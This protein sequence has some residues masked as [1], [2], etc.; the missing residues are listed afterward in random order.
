[1]SWNTHSSNTWCASTSTATWNN[2]SQTY[3]Y[4]H[5]DLDID[6][7]QFIF[8]LVVDAGGRVRRSGW[9]GILF[10][11]E[12][13]FLVLDKGTTMSRY[14]V[15]EELQ[16]IRDHRRCYTYRP[17]IEDKKHYDALML[18]RNYRKKMNKLI[19]WMQENPNANPDDD[20]K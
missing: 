1:M 7:L 3:Y 18:F 8:N 19:D 14:E 12:D 13:E 9:L 17:H 10:Q 16:R 15:M 20:D 4:K 2:H 11:I 5:I 6:G